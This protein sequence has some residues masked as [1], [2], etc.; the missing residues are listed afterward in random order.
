INFVADLGALDVFKFVGGDR[1]FTLVADVD[2]NLLGTDFDDS[3]F[4]DLARGKALV[5]LLQ[6]FF[7]AKHN[8]FSD[9]IAG[10][11]VGAMRPTKAP[12]PNGPGV[13]VATEVEGHVVR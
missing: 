1:A 13:A 6:G 11:L 3:A 7:H 8:D 5:A 2:Q 4:D 9:S 12:L 10:D